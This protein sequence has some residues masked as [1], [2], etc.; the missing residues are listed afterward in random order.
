[1]IEREELRRLRDQ[2]EAGFTWETLQRQHPKERKGWRKKFEKFKKAHQPPEFWREFLETHKEGLAELHPQLR[3]WVEKAARDGGALRDLS[4]L[5]KD[6][7]GRDHAFHHRIP[8]AFSGGKTLEEIN[9]PSNLML[10][11]KAAHHAFDDAFY[12]RLSD[13]IERGQDVRL[14]VAKAGREAIPLYGELEALGEKKAELAALGMAK[15]AIA[16]KNP[17]RSAVLEQQFRKSYAEALAQAGD[18]AAKQEILTEK[19]AEANRR[20]E[21][22]RRARE[23]PREPLGPRGL[24]VIEDVPTMGR[25]MGSAF[26]KAASLSSAASAYAEAGQAGEELRNGKVPEAARD[27]VEAA[28]AAANALAPAARVFLRTPGVGMV[29]K[30]LPVMGALAGF[31]EAGYDAYRAWRSLRTGDAPEAADRLRQAAWRAV[32]G[33][34]NLVLS[35]AG[36]WGMAGALAA[37]ALA[38]QQAARIEDWRRNRSPAKEA[39]PGGDPHGGISSAAAEGRGRERGEELCRF[40]YPAREEKRHKGALRP[41]RP[42]EPEKEPGRPCRAGWGY[43]SGPRR[44]PPSRGPER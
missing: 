10:L 20:K 26:G 41:E 27:G 1:M 11:P 22:W 15:E 18:P 6:L 8:L 38:E 43:V 28:G 3:S 37:S 17:G 34:A 24:P 42:E 44:P 12:D 13:W 4:K 5:A 21:L 40:P 25:V 2:F 23:N 31:A 14:P 30:R 16:I 36:P 19:Q 7:T 32:G 29:L 9:A 35:G 39:V 33:A